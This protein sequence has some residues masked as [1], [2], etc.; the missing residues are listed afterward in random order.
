MLHIHRTSRHRHTFNTSLVKPGTGGTVNTGNSLATNLVGAWLFNENTGTTVT[1]ISTYGNGTLTNGPTW[2]TGNFSNSAVSCDGTNDYILIDTPSYGN[3]LGMT[4]LSWINI[5][6]TVLTGQGRIFMMIGGTSYGGMFLHDG[7]AEKLKFAISDG[8]G[9]NGA[10]TIL[11]ISGD[12][13]HQVAVTYSQAAGVKLYLDGAE[14][15]TDQTNPTTLSGTQNK[16]YLCSNDNT[17]TY[18]LKCKMDHFFLWTR[19]LAGSEIATLYSYP[20]AFLNS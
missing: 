20:F 19:V 13:W 16:I 18:P 17:P 9:E 11:Q 6:S 2:T 4:A 5:D 14:S 3:Y 15:S 10:R 7:G 12:T 1:G 8:A